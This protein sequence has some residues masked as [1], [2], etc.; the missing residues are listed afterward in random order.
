MTPLPRGEGTRLELLVGEQLVARIRVTLDVQTIADI[1]D[2]I[3]YEQFL[4][5]YICVEADMRRIRPCER[6]ESLTTVNVVV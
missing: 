4:C 5:A 3:A 1:F 2:K 6:V